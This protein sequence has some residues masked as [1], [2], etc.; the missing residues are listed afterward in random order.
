MGAMNAILLL[1]MGT[2]VVCD[3][4]SSSSKSY[5]LYIWFV[6]LFPTTIY[7]KYLYKFDKMVIICQT[8]LAI[9]PYF[10]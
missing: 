8:E 10:A 9:F 4:Y 5:H 6:V 2:D 3:N 7:L 1:D